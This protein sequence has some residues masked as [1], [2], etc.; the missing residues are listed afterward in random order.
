MNKFAGADWACA[1]GVFDDSR[2]ALLAIADIVI[3][4]WS[5]SISLS[6]PTS[7]ESNSQCASHCRSRLQ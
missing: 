1:P 7:G 3:D 6:F 5:I 2:A 4:T